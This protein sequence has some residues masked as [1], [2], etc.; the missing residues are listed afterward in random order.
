MPLRGGLDRTSLQ[1]LKA[2][3]PVMK[4]FTCRYVENIFSLGTALLQRFQPKVVA[5]VFSADDGSRMLIVV[6]NI[7]GSSNPGDLDLSES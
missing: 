3:Q 6:S 4:L 1:W 2:I 7:L 5:I